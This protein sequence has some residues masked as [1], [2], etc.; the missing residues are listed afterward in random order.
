MQTEFDP[1]HVWLGI[2][3]EEQPPNRYRL[4][5]IPLFESN[6]DVIAMAAD[7]QMGHLRTFQSGKHSDL[8]Q[9]LL[10]DVA[11]AKVCLLN[12]AK[13]AAYDEQLRQ[14]LAPADATPIPPES[15]QWD[16]ITDYSSSKFGLLTDRST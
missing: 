16:A 10:N 8:S 9:R 11:A 7:R 6:A 4:L 3:P 5:G 1:F 15:P 14:Q 2:P 12:S 13:K